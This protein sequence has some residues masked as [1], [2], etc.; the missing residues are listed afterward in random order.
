MTADPAEAVSGRQVLVL[1]FDPI[2]EEMPGPAIRAWHLACELG[3]R[4]RVVLASTSRANRTNPNITVKSVTPDEIPQLVDWADVMFAPTSVVRRHPAVAEAAKPLC[5]DMYIPTHLENLEPLG[6]EGRADRDTAVQH[7]I[8]VVAEDLRRGDF[9]LCASERQRDFWLGGLSA[10]GRVNP[11]T[12]MAD[13][14]LRRLIDVVPFGRPDGE[15]VTESPGL[16]QRYPS[17]GPSDQVVIW[18]GGVYN[19]FDPLSLVRAI[20]E[21]RHGRPNIRAL[22][23]GMR[24]P[25]P[26]IPAMRVASDLRQLSDELGLTDQHVFFNE[27]WVPYDQ[28]AGFLLESDIGVSTHLAHIE[29]RFS[30]R[31]R[32]LDYLWAGLP[33]VLT[34]GDTLSEELTEA[35]FALSVPPGDPAAIANAIA[36]L[37]DAPPSR[38]AIRA[39]G[40][41]YRWSQVG[42]PLFAYCDAPWRAADTVPVPDR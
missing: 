14:T 7:Q 32:V 42:A 26:D 9:F 20:D 21:L 18:A 38:R 25:N 8:A 10:E 22:F 11:Q 33:M 3:R 17:I 6:Q 19:W 30:F 13:P 29:T 4:H 31:T 23:L 1:A 28:R 40:R 35:G 15:P 36:R 16:R 39:Y 27:G 41:R 24:N 2:T 37:L 34:E 12:Y 5:I